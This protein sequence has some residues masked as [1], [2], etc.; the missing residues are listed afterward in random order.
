MAPTPPSKVADPPAGRARLIS[1]SV[2]VLSDVGEVSSNGAC[3]ETASGTPA[4]ASG[5]LSDRASTTL[6]ADSTAGYSCAE[7]TIAVA[8]RSAPLSRVEGSGADGALVTTTL[9]TRCPLVSVNH[10]LP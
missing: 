3:S 4:T 10:R 9:A 1:V 5:K 8:M 6:F 2:V 7:T